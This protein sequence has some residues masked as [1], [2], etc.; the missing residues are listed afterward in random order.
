MGQ[1][2]GGFGGT[3]GDDHQRIGEVG[4][5][6]AEDTWEQGVLMHPRGGSPGVNERFGNTHGSVDREISKHTLEMINR[7][8]NNLQTRRGG[9]NHFGPAVEE[10][11]PPVTESPIHKN[12]DVLLHGSL[13]SGSMPR[14]ARGTRDLPS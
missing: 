10:L 6:A 4:T 3:I 5:A 9:E 1:G 14:I 12:G 11:G 2:V 7:R 13:W 8:D